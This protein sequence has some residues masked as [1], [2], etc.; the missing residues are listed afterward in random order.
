MAA[1]PPAA[2]ATCLP[3]P[4]GMSSSGHNAVAVIITF[5]ALIVGGKKEP[6]HGHVIVVYPGPDK[7]AGG[8]SY[9]RGGKT[10]TLR[11]RGSYPP[12]MS[13]SLG[14]WAGA[15]SKGDKT[16]WDPWA[17]DA[18]FAHVTFWQLVQ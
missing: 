1:S 14:G 18:K 16:I 15:R 7:A 11:T 17:S 4:S 3:P 9:T 5:G 10:E 8:Y 13:T 6:G 12:A 2:G